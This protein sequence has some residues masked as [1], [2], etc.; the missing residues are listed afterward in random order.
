MFGSIKT[1]VSFSFVWYVCVIVG[2]KMMVW[3]GSYQLRCARCKSCG[4]GA[5]GFVAENISS[6]IFFLVCRK[7]GKLLE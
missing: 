3:Q 5:E 1:L 2:C 4:V 6:A 7:R